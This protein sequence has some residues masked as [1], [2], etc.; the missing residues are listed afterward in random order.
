VSEN[1]PRRLVGLK[2]EPEGL[3][4]VVAKASGEAVE[5]ALRRRAAGGR[6]APVVRN[7]ALLEELFR[8]PLD[9]PIGRELF[10]VV[11]V[12]LAHVLDVEAKLAERADA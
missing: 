3:P 12:L 10:Q 6:A 9:A 4:Q 2:Y 11:A 7:E 5:E 1:S 8:L